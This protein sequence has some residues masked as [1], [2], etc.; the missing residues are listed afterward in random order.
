MP[1]SNK[2]SNIS[3]ET[4]E[5]INNQIKKC[6]IDLEVIPITNFCNLDSKETKKPINENLRKIGK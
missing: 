2:S 3:H 6:E 4:Q 5:I 1:Q